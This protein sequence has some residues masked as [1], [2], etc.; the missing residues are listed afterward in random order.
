MRLGKPCTAQLTARCRCHVLRKRSF[1]LSVG[2]PMYIDAIGV[3]RGVPN[4]Y[5]LADQI[6]AGFKTL[7]VD[8]GIISIIPITPN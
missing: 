3:P 1:Y 7:P 5:K 4:E 6:V 2:S 8:V